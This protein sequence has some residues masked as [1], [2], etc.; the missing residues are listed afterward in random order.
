MLKN[1]KKKRMLKNQLS[2]KY[3]VCYDIYTILE[4]KSSSTTNYFRQSIIPWI[5]NLLMIHLIKYFY[6]NCII[7]SHIF[8]NVSK[9]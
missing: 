8:V 4:N 2:E 1:Q 6:Y 9:L 5:M 3:P 7:Y